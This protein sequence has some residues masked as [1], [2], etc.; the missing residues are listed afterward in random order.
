MHP[1]QI[2]M[3]GTMAFAITIGFTLLKEDPEVQAASTATTQERITISSYTSTQ[4][5]PASF[6]QAIGTSSDEEVFDALYNGKSLADIATDHQQDAQ[7]VIDL[8][9]AQMTEQLS[10]RLASGSITP[11]MYYAQLAE[12]PSIISES[13]Y[14]HK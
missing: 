3:V 8:Q 1:K 13:V 5:T 11:S 6:E 9:V 12:L 2:I 4:D 7:G 14:G 10:D